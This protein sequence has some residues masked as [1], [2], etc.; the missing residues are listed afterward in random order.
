MDA[1]LQT[2]KGTPLGPAGAPNRITLIS[3]AYGTITLIVTA[4]AGLAL[5]LLVARRL[6][7]RL[8]SGKEE[9][10]A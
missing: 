2:I 5:V 3:T 1:L 8:R 7:R 9:R 6:I 4:T 10:T